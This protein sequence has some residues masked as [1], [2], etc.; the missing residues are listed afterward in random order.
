M[1]LKIS[2]YAGFSNY[3]TLMACFQFLGATVNY[4]E[5][6]FIK[7]LIEAEFS[8]CCII[9]AT[10]TFICETFICSHVQLQ[11]MALFNYKNHTFKNS[12][13]LT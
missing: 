7:Q 6:D 11:Q 3:A 10:E 4:L 5:Y 13:G 8:E 9:K 2:F 12:L 1:T